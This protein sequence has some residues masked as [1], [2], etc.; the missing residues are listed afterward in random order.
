MVVEW[1]AAA[2]VD[3]PDRGVGE[4]S[5]IEVEWLAP[6]Q[7][8]VRYA[9]ER[10]ER[11]DRVL[12]LRQ[13]RWADAHRRAADIPEGAVPLTEATARQP[14]LAQ[15]RGERH[16]EPRRLLT[17]LDALERVVHVDQGALRGHA[18]GQRADGAGR[19]L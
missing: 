7:Q 2:P 19:N 14:D 6:V 5:A 8:H 10:D 12:A 1:V 15:H 3:E 17:V 4:T 16:A 9:R 18:S 13:C 11:V